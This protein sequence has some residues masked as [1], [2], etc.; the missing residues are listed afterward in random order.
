MGVELKSL[1]FVNTICMWLDG[2]MGNLCPEFSKKGMTLV[3]KC[4]GI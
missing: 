2:Y 4:L 3:C 1:P